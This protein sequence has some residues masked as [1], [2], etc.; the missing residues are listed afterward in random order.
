M[1]GYWEAFG[2]F[3]LLLDIYVFRDLSCM[4][5]LRTVRLSALRGFVRFLVSFWTFENG[6][7]TFLLG[8]QF[9]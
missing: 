7:V 9:A 5:G 8:R 6:L 4:R 2:L 1:S 3:G